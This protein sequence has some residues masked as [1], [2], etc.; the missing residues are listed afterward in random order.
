MLR[1]ASE[2]RHRG[3][4]GAGHQQEQQRAA[5]RGGLLAHHG[6]LGE[7]GAAAAEALGDVDADEALLG[8]GLGVSE[9]QVGLLVSGYAAVVA[10]GSVPMAALLER[11]GIEP[12]EKVRTRFELSMKYAVSKA[13]RMD[14]LR[15]REIEVVGGGDTPPGIELHGAA[16]ARAAELGVRV[17]VSL[18]HTRTTAAAVAVLA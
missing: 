8:Q 1:G 18:T 9:S 7:P 17:H 11:L 14:V 10:V 13:L 5:L 3:A 4:D 2:G 16:A 6:Q 12:D 15:P